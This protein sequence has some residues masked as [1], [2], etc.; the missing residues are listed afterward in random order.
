LLSQAARTLRERPEMTQRETF[1]RPSE[2]ETAEV[3][4]L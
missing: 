3:A 1:Q 4:A 2:R